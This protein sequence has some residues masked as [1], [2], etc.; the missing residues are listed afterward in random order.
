[1]SVGKKTS[2]ITPTNDLYLPLNE[3]HNIIFERTQKIDLAKQTAVEKY[4]EGLYEIDPIFETKT[5][6]QNIVVVR[7]A[8]DDYLE[9]KDAEFSESGVIVSAPTKKTSK[10]QME[11]DG[12]K[13]VMIDNP[14]PYLMYGVVVAFDQ[15]ILR[16]ADSEGVL[17]KNLKVGATVE[18]SG[19]SLQDHIYYTD[20]AKGDSPIPKNELIDGANPF[21][22]YEGYVQ[23]TPGH[24]ECF[25]PKLEF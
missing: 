11:T 20:K 16:K 22:N 1:M 3:A 5:F 15:D 4:N 7:L 12:G 9:T 25:I 21:P 6:T 17:A 23:I 14:V 13:L 10:I 8:K 24:I 18:I 19:L 2:I